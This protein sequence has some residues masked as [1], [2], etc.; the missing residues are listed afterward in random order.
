MASRAPLGE[1]GVAIGGDDAPL[2]RKFAESERAA[3]AFYKRMSA[4]LARI[5]IGGGAAGSN[6]DAQRSADR[7]GKSLDAAAKAGNRYHQTIVQVAN[8]NRTLIQIIDNSTRT[9]NNQRTSIDNSSRSLSNITN[10]YRQ[11]GAAAGGMERETRRADAAAGDLR[12]TLLASASVIVGA[13]GANEVKN[14]ADSYTRFT[15]Q[16]KV[17]GLEGS[18]L[19]GTQEKLFGQAQKYGVEL[20]SLGTLYGRLAQSQSALGAT[21][22]QMIQF[23][24]GVAAAIKVQG[25]G[26]NEVKGALLQLSQAMGSPIVRAEE[27]NSV[28][29]G[30]RPIL[31]AVANG[32]DRYGGSVAKLRNEVIAGKVTSQEFFQGFLRGSGQ[33]EAQSEK[34]NL[35]IGA[36]FQTLNNALG[37]YIGQTDKSLSATQRVGGA[38]KLLADNLNTVVPILTAI[39]IAMGARYVVA[40]GSMVASTAL[41]Q[42]AM[43]AFRLVTQGTLVSV[44]ALGD[45]AVVAGRSLLAAFGGP[46]GI[47]IMAI[48]GAVY[49]FHQRAAEASAEIENFNQHQKEAARVLEAERVRAA[50][51]G[52]AIKQLGSDHKTATANVTAFAGATGDAAKALYEQARAARRA[53]F[54]LLAMTLEQAKADKAAADARVRETQQSGG[55]VARFGYMP[56]SQDHKDAVARS[57]AAQ[58]TID[59]TQAAIDRAVKDPLESYVPNA[60]TGGRDIAAEIKDLQ[61]QLVNAE[62]AHN[63]AAQRELLKQIKIR[64]R[65]TALMAQGLSLEIANAT[66]ETE[67]T[68]AP[69]AVEEGATRFGR[70][71]Q[72]GT[73]RGTV[74][75]KRPGHTHAGTDYAVPVGTPVSATAGGT[76]I[77]AGTLPGYGN[78]II[79]DHGRGMT[80]RYAHLSRIGVAKGA[81]V[82]AGDQIGLSGGARGAPGAGNSQGPH[83]HYEV[84]K[85]GKPVDPNGLYAT[86]EV[87]AQNKAEQLANQRVQRDQTFGAA[88]Q[89]LNDAILAAREGQLVD[90]A[91]IAEAAKTRVNAERDRERDEIEN[92]RKR[93][94]YSVDPAINN[95]RAAELTTANENLRTEQLAGIDLKER[96]R[97]ETVLTRTLADQQDRKMEQLQ[98]EEDLAR[99]A[100]ERRAVERRILAAQ[101]EFERKTLQATI[102]SQF[103]K[104]EDRDRAKADLANLD[105]RYQGRSSRLDRDAIQDM[106]GTAPDGTSTGIRDQERGVRR[107][108]DDRLASVDEG[109]AALLQNEQ[110]TQEQREKILQEAADRRVQIE[111]DAAKRIL[112]LETQRKT[113]QLQNAQD[114]ADGLATIAEGIA[115]KQSGLYRGLFATAKAFAIAQASIALYQNVAEAMK[116]GFPQNLP[117]IAAAVAQGATIMSNIQ[118]ISGSFKVGGFTGHGNDNDEAGVV[119]RNE[120]VFDANATRRIGKQN[121]DMIRAGRNPTTAI[122]AAANDSGGLANAGASKGRVMVKQMPGVAIEYRESM[123]SGDVEIIAQRAVEKHAPGVVAADMD[124]PNG[125]VRKSVQR[126]TTA[127]GRK[128]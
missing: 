111:M 20:E 67:G 94:E 77:E 124:R 19:T 82:G 54:D 28:N 33:L 84:R 95:T 128:S 31:Q 37:R 73:I 79:I 99:T 32:I 114:I 93:N 61:T 50:T 102:D 105:A 9:F 17:A 98:A 122:R 100:V 126:N 68:T 83:L 25:A 89:Q 53:R 110:L 2:L 6:T 60:R 127:R 38:I 10:N 1:V 75:E 91:K 123:T 14:L 26:A 115:G 104:P 109:T 39:I 64:Q 118:A 62:K 7:V 48:A 106:Y 27:F 112:D 66:A 15:N 12:R 51:A 108:R 35:T 44:V 23:T 97:L 121:L 58:K 24:N 69:K 47:A 85:G 81:T 5:P 113:L 52:G 11:A 46:V 13:F 76:V 96:Q 71:V 4:K 70:P 22:G 36:S 57:A 49:F 55:S 72:G 42:L 107:D 29:E 56:E 116:Y 103:T 92:R 74:G 120:Y 63:V 65:I 125:K 30:A 90:E 78:V 21:S 40:A 3:D 16:L 43:A 34:A 101:K 18:A 41:A 86:D 88:Q 119:H 87:D 80:T 59:A 8:D 117:F 45:A